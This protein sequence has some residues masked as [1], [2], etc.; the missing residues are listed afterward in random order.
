MAELVDFFL[1]GLWTAGVSVNFDS[2]VGIDDIK[3]WPGPVLYSGHLSHL[4]P[5]SGLEHRGL[6][7]LHIAVPKDSVGATDTFYLPESD[8]LFGRVSQPARFSDDFQADDVDILCAEIPEGRHG[9]AVDFTESADAIQEQLVKAGIL[10]PSTPIVEIEQTF[11]PRV[12]PLYTRGWLTRWRAA[13]NQVLDFGEVFPVGTLGL[14]P[15]RHVVEARAYDDTPWVRVEAPEL[16]FDLLSVHL[17]FKRDSERQVQLA[18]LSEGLRRRVEPAPHQVVAGDFN[19]GAEG[20]PLGDFIRREGL[21]AVAGGA[22]TFPASAP[23]RR[24]DYLLSSPG[25]EVLRQEVIP[26]E[27][28]DHLPVLLDLRAR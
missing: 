24:I 9:P 17:D 16:S 21:R 10:P 6:Y 23:T 27:V 22:D 1:T 3:S 25:L 20:P 19:C 13:L 15:G 4:T 11:L 12:Y 18:A 26:I 5:E 28:S 8:F 2:A 7:L 14:S